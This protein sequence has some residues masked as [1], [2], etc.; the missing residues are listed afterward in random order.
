MEMA[1]YSVTL[2]KGVGMDN[3][4]TA[5]DVADALGLDIQT[6]Y[7]K[8]VDLG[9]VK[10]ARKWF[11]DKDIVRQRLFGEALEEHVNAEQKETKRE[12]NRMVGASAPAGSE[13]KQ[14]M[15]DTAGSLSPRGQVARRDQ[16]RGRTDNP[17]NLG[18]G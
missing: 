3:L 15:L 7:R 16:A 5:Q 17:H 1:W 6:V 10:F 18:M 13:K 2:G 4:W 12:N 8:A 9:G 14:S 11:F